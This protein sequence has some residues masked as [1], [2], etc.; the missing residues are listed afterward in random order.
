[1]QRALVDP[2]SYYCLVNGHL[3]SYEYCKVVDNWIN[4][5]QTKKTPYGLAFICSDEH[6]GAPIR[7]YIDRYI[8]KEHKAADID[9][10]RGYVNSILCTES[11]PDPENYMARL[12]RSDRAGTGKTLQKE[13]L[14]RKLRDDLEV[15]G[16]DV[17]IP[18]YK[19]IEVDKL[20]SRL[21]EELSSVVHRSNLIHIDIAS[22]VSP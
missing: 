4:S 7:G 11:S 3:L 17:T 16:H 2:Y 14:R 12:V 22:E 18:I 19:T 9:V 5:V 6:R 21:H 10:I 20:V 15:E 13:N 1:M 8:I